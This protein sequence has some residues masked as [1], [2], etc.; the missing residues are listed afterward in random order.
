MRYPNLIKWIKRK[1]PTEKQLR[2]HIEGRFR[3]LTKE[4][5]IDLFNEARK[6]IQV[7]KG[8]SNEHFHHQI[9]NDPN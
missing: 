6:I 9:R 3:A 4:E 2:L 7:R 5:R 8:I 1:S